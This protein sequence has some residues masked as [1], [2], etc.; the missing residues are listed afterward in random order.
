MGNDNATAT[1]DGEPGISYRPADLQPLKELFGELTGDDFKPEYFKQFKEDDDLNADDPLAQ[2]IG[3][4]SNKE[5]AASIGNNSSLI[6]T[7]NPN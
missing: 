4:T 7:V 2:V 3:F 1:V 5:G 6:L